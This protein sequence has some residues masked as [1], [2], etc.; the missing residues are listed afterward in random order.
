MAR[1]AGIGKSQLSKYESGKELPKLDSL[2]KVL[3][4]LNVGHWKLEAGSIASSSLFLSKGA[5]V[6]DHL[7]PP[8]RPLAESMSAISVA[9][10]NAPWKAGLEYLL[11]SALTG[12]T[13]G[14]LWSISPE[15]TETLRER[16]ESC[17]GWIAAKGAAP[18]WVP[19]RSWKRMYRE[20][21]KKKE[22]RVGESLFTREE[23]EVELAARRR[24]LLEVRKRSQVVQVDL[25]AAFENFFE[26]LGPD[27][28]GMRPGLVRWWRGG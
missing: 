8:R 16:L 22:I 28:S 18:E 21:Q 5:S 10:F 13:E 15:E 20:H 19:L 2:E 23:Y 6:F 4:V 12:A 7:T 14:M 3:L 1:L 17:R 9:W 25:E 27:I 26:A 11:W 24:H